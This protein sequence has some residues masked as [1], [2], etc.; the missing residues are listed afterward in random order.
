MRHDA[1]RD[2]SGADVSASHHPAFSSVAPF[3]VTGGM[4]DGREE[5]GQIFELQPHPVM[6][7]TVSGRPPHVAVAQGLT[8]RRTVVLTIQWIRTLLAHTPPR[9]LEI[10]FPLRQ[11]SAAAGLSEFWPG[12]A[13][14]GGLKECHRAACSLF[15]F[16]ETT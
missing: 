12:S 6:E 10:C 3:L 4:A 14:A 2:G 8:P 13:G 7:P 5:G 1:A 9:W 11:E 16:S 15:L